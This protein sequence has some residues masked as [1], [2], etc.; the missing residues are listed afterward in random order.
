[1]YFF[2]Q[3]IKIEKGDREEVIRAPNTDQR[4]LNELFL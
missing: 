4:L 2:S 1:M 3:R